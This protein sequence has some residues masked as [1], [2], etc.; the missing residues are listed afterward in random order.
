MANARKP[1]D[2]YA[3]ETDAAYTAFVIFR[4]LGPTRSIVEAYRRRK[5][6]QVECRVHA[7]QAGGGWNRWAGE[8]RWMERALA[9]DSHLQ[10]QR[11]LE[12]KRDM[13]REERRKR[14][15]RIRC[16]K[17]TTKILSRIDTLLSWPISRR[18]VEEHKDGKSVTTIIEP[19]N[20]SLRDV[21]A[22][23][24]ALEKIKIIGD[25]MR[26]ERQ[27]N[28]PV[29]SMKAP[30]GRVKFVRAILQPPRQ[31]PGDEPKPTEE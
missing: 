22:L 16:D 30:T 26:A 6:G 4:D 18:T 27:A 2:R 20:V 11:D 29:E 31:F 5:T 8:F 9:W 17:T 14:N 3:R 15:L 23:T 19:V 24:G 10:E 13:I 28:E 7:K 1:W 21:G 25:Q 12:Y